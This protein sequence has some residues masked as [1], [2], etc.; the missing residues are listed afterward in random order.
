METIYIFGHKK[1]DTDSVTSAIAL[2]YLKNELGYNTKPYVLGEINNETKFVLNF[3]KIET[4]QYLNDIKQQIKDVHYQKGFFSNYKES[5]Y[6]SYLYMNR[7]LISTLPIVDDNNKFLGMISMKDIAH[8]QV[9]G[10]LSKLNSSYENIVNTL[11][12]EMILKFNNEINGHI[13][14]AAFKSSSFIENVEIKNN[15]VLI[16]G[17]RYNIIECAVRGRAKLI[18]LTNNCD[19]SDE[20]LKLAKKNR[21]NIIKT[22]FASFKVAKIINLCN[23]IY[24]IA[25]TKNII[26]FNEFESISSFIDVSNKYKYTSYPIIN[27]NKE[28]LGILKVSDIVNK[29]RKKVI[30]VDHNDYEQSVDGLEEAEILEIIDHHKIGSISTNLPI[31]FRNMPVGSTNSIIYN[32]FREYNIEIP[33]NIAGL[34]LSGIIS[35]TLLLTSPTTTSIDKNIVNELEQ[36]TGLNYKDFGMDLFKAGASLKGKSKTEVIYTD[37]KNF[38]FYNHKV[39]IGQVFTMNP[40]EILNEINEYVTLINN[41]AKNNEYYLLGLFITDIL[42]NGTY[43]LFNDTASHLLKNCFNLDS[44]KQGEFLPG[45]VSRK[46]QFIPNI[47]N[48]LEKK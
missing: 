34:M 37:F 17:D 46:K 43:I 18:I 7:N 31:S 30:L 45:L 24:T 35:D 26:H 27:N 23:Y 36:I 2:S 1:P 40:K 11:K 48:V 22:S 20:H 3:F 29:K 42:N 32:M 47:I 33:Y 15:T 12:G 5:I 9:D 25:N 28:C 38:T 8:D 10:D 41:I 16:V 13:L 19:I 6:N 21:V 14:V 39:G 4:P 44:V